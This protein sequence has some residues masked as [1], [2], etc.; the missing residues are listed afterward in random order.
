MATNRLHD[1]LLIVS[2]EVIRVL[3]PI[4]PSKTTRKYNIMLKTLPILVCKQNT[5]LRGVSRQIHHLTSPHY[6]CISLSISS[7]VVLS[8]HM[9]GSALTITYKNNNNTNT[10][11]AHEILVKI[12]KV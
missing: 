7:H 5:T 10:V 8:V 9:C 4:A 1:N 12:Y 3:K 6:H 11:K 2:P